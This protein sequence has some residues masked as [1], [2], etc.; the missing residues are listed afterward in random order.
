M[1]KSVGSCNKAGKEEGNRNAVLHGV[2]CCERLEFVEAPQSI[3][4]F[5]LTKVSVSESWSQ[6]RLSVTCS[7]IIPANQIFSSIESRLRRGCKNGGSKKDSSLPSF[8]L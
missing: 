5:L 1:E 8:G 2:Y 3:V 7:K 4:F 6:P